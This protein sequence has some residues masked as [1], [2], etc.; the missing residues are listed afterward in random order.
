MA[1][2][3]P[4]LAYLADRQVHVLY[5][6][7]ESEALTSTFVEDVRRRASSIERKTAWKTRGTG[8]RFMGAAALWDDAEGRRPP[9]AFVSLAKGRKPGEILYAITTGPVS[10]LFAMDVARGGAAGPETRLVHGTDGAALSIATSDDHR[11][12]AMAR[13]QKS[14]ACN[15]AVMRDDGGDTALVTDG[16]T[17]DSSPSWVPVARDA[18]EGRHQLVYQCTAIGRDETGALAGFAPSEIHLLDAEHATLKTI[19]AD[20]KHDYSAPTMGRD[21]ALFAVRRPYAG[22]DPAIPTPG[23][24]LKDGLFAPFRLMYAGFRYLDFFTMRYTGKPLTTS[25]NARGRHV[26]ARRL[27]ERQNVATAGGEVEDETPRAPDDWTLV[28]REPGSG[29]ETVI[30][31]SVVAYAPERDGSWLVSDGGAVLRVDATGGR[32][33]V[34][35]KIPRVTSLVS[36]A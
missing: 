30:A 9:A 15:L 2:R 32:P 29:G 34:L 19:V 18:T 6:D 28:R 4:R 11:V 33:T 22:H 5:D 20:E 21:G 24:V 27:L 16:D 3:V 1:S 12:I 17:I 35:A 8:A 31:R 10:G 26:D 7:G 13:S 36:L 14:G 23:A 25:G